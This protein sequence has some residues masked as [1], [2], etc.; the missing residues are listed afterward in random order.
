M[1]ASL[2]IEC[3]CS[4]VPSQRHFLVEQL[5]SH[6]HMLGLCCRAMSVLRTY[7]ECNLIVRMYL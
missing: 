4:L 3:F 7:L 5:I 2:G 1:E 6:K